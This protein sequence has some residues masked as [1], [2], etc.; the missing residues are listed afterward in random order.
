MAE[1][2]CE[3]TDLLVSQC[4]HC[5]GHD[6]RG[7]DLLGDRSRTDGTRTSAPFQARYRSGCGCCVDP[8]E[9]GDDI[10]MWGGAATHAQCAA[11]DGGLVPGL[12]APSFTPRRNPPPR[13]RGPRTLEDPYG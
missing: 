8:I 4:A 5:Q 3:R 13:P 1:A 7:F 2:R 11:D 6:I 12:N 9:V 10:V